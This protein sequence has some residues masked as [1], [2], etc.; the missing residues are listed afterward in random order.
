MR[1][2]VSDDKPKQAQRLSSLE[3]VKFGS[4][5]YQLFLVIQ[6]QILFLRIY[7]IYDS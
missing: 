1:I 3:M 2:E 4:M 6:C 5:A 7:E